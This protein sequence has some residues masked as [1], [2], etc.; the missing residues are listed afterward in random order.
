MEEGWRRMKAVQRQE[1]V[2][3][4]ILTGM[5]VLLLLLC[6]IR[7]F[8]FQSKSMMSTQA[9]NFKADTEST[10]GGSKTTFPS[11]VCWFSTPGMASVNDTIQVDQQRHVCWYVE[12]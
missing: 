12:I 10:R 4:I 1:V 2:G 3:E 7:I 5:Y 6:H 11:Y 9:S 8:F